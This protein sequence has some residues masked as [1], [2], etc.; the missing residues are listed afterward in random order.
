MCRNFFFRP[1][2]KMR[3][4][5]SHRS[6]VQSAFLLRVAK[7]RQKLLNLPI[8]A[9]VSFPF[10]PKCFHFK[11]TSVAEGLT[12]G[13]RANR[14]N[15][16]FLVPAESCE[17]RTKFKNRWGCFLKRESN[18]KH[19]DYTSVALKFCISITKTTFTLNQR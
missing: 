2:S 7:N 16:N 10:V 6:H 3:I 8:F 1:V 11:R 14:L 5:S 4:S 19:G 13:S 15:N 12:S 9:L 17:K 18:S